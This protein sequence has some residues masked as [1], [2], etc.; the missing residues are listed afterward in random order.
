VPAIPLLYGA[1]WAE[2]STKDY[3]GW[4]TQS[5]AYS[6]PGPNPSEVEYVILQL[7]PV[8]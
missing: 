5:D 3:T 4:P 8:S 6:D 1:S 7:K 2:W